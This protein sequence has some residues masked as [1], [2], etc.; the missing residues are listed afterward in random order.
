MDAAFDKYSRLTLP[1][2]R[3]FEIYMDRR[4]S[5]ATKP[6]S[7]PPELIWPGHAEQHAPGAN[8]R[9]LD[10]HPVATITIG[11]QPTPF[12]RRIVQHAKQE[13]R[14]HIATKKWPSKNRARAGVYTEIVV[15]SRLAGVFNSIGQ[16]AIMPKSMESDIRRQPTVRGPVIRPAPPRI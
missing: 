14:F 12:M 4:K 15:A 9:R 11:W 10:L 16:G 2:P 13:Q 6:L 7:R 8:R 3:P 1:P 5:A